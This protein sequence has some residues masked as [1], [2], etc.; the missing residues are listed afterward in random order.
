LET[1]LQPGPHGPYPV[2]KDVRV[3]RNRLVRSTV[4]LTEVGVSQRDI[5]FCLEE[6]LDTRLSAAWVNAELSRRE[7]LAAGVNA[8]WQPSVTETLSGDEIYSNGSPNLLLVGNDSLYIYSLTRQPTCDGETWG[9]V[10]LDT[11]NCPQFSSD[12][13]LGLAAGAKEAGL[14]VHQ[15]DWDHLLRPLCQYSP[16]SVPLFFGK[17]VP[18]VFGQT[19]H[20]VNGMASF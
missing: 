20:P 8:S 11:P 3:D 10:L 14:S 18:R 2:K 1:G 7:G 4:V 5:G 13:G 6:M 19:R 16:E 15:L 9:C 12:G 17:S